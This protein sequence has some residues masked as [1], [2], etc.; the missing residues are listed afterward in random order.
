MVTDE[1][2]QKLWSRIGA[3]GSDEWRGVA[4]N[5]LDFITTQQIE[6]E[7]LRSELYAITKGWY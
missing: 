2:I 7:E 6:I 3:T 4:G 5:L 1:D